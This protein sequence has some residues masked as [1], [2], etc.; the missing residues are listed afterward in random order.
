MTPTP[1][2]VKLTPEQ[3]AALNASGEDKVQPVAK[4]TAQ[5]S[6]LVA[7]EIVRQVRAELF[8]PTLKPTLRQMLMH[9]TSAHVIG[10]ALAARDTMEKIRERYRD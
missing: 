10:H 8:G 6:Q 4:P 7:R 2:V 9:R 5:R 1:R 3:V